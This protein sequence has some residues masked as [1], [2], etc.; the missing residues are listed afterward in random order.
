[1]ACPRVAHRRSST[2]SQH[3]NPPALNSSGRRPTV[4]GFVLFRHANRPNEIAFETRT[5]VSI[6]MLNKTGIILYVCPG[7]RARV[8]ERDQIGDVSRGGFPCAKLS[9]RSRFPARNLKPA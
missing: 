8:S 7:E 6:S 1:M 9:P 2:S 5:E 3:S 4:Q